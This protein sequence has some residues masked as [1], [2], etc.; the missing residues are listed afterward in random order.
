MTN[1]IKLPTLKCLRCGH[2]WI[3][4]RPVLPKTCPKCISTYWNR[5]RCRERGGKGIDLISTNPYYK[6]VAD[7]IKLPILKCLRC[8]HE[9]IPRQLKKPK[10]CASCNSPC[11]DRPK[12]KQSGLKRESI[13]GVELCDDDACDADEDGKQYFGD[14]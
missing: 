8:G 4:R 3:P 12:V 7:T 2:S 11:W 9:W 5:P 1:K 6:G 14:E 10:Y 13:P